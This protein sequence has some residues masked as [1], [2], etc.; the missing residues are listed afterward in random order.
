[1]QRKIIHCDCDCFYAAVEVR[2]RPDLAGRPVAVGGTPERRGVIATC[3]YE[4]RRYGVHSAMPS[5]HA[6]RACP[7]LVLLRPDMDKYRE[8]SRSVFGIF[9]RF[10]DRIEPLSLDEG[11][12]DVTG[13]ELLHGSA[14]LIAQAIR[15]SVRRELGI[16]ISAGIAPNKF[17]AKIASD[18][19]KPDGQFVVR[20]D[21]VDAFVAAL[22][23]KRLPGVGP[24]MTARLA[25][26]GIETCADLRR[27]DLVTLHQKL[28]SAAQRLRELANG[29]DPRQVSARS[30][31]KSV[32]VETTYAED[33]PNLAACQRALE[34]L[35]VRLKERLAGMDPDD[36]IRSC[37]VKV[38]F[39]D[40][41]TTTAERAAQEPG[42]EDF[43]ALLESAWS[44]GERPVRL[45]GLGVH[46]SNRSAPGEQ[47]EL[48]DAARSAD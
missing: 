37:F 11:Y 36:R 14:T 10:T 45:L 38:R 46:F 12:L 35:E 15:N 34:E 3:N 5:S 25:A 17:L 7:D 28:G 8:V 30:G 19:N 40:F 22:P 18:W 6:V 43:A 27:M 48:F 9:K 23:V 21:D 2:D 44:R 1:M 24:A 33:K 26:L 47:L 32:S 4:A 20:P 16:T 29:E 42:G 31:R 41:T 39:D 13:S